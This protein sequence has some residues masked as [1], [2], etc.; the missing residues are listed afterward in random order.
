[1]PI[2][3]LVWI[4]PIGML[5]DYKKNDKYLS[6]AQSIFKSKNFVLKAGIDTSYKKISLRKLKTAFQI[7]QCI[8]N[9]VDL[10]IISVPTL[11]QMEYI[12]K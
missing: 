11:A 10:I 2:T 12:K 9:L 7:L 1:M 4:R 6:H 5:Y 3:T 8:Q